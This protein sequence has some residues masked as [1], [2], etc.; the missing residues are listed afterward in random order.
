MGESIDHPSVDRVIT[1][2][3]QGAWDATRHLLSRGATRIAMIAG[4]QDLDNDRIN[5]YR[6]ALR[7]VGQRYQGSGS[8][9]VTGPVT[10]AGRPCDS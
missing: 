9:T 1:D 5:G 6:S 2:G 3:E 4:S 10:G 7:S 8:P